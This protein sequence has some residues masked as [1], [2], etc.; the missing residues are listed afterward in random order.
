MTTTRAKPPLGLSRT[1]VQRDTFAAFMFHARRVARVP[2]TLA[3][4]LDDTPQAV[5]AN[6][7][8]H[9]VQAHIF[10]RPEGSALLE[11]SIDG[12]VLYAFER[13]NPYDATPGG[14]EVVINVASDCVT[15]TAQ[16]TESEVTWQSHEHGRF[17]AHGVVVEV[18]DG[19]A[20]LD[21]GWP[22]VVFPAQGH[23]FQVG[24]RFQVDSPWPVHAFIRRSESHAATHEPIDDAV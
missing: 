23:E 15:A 7:K 3:A 14:H 9:G 19:Y 16:G 11:L 13:T 18:G 1:G 24:G 6:F 17:T 20:V 5:L 21:V 4:M 8:S 10:A 12:R 22:L 2:G